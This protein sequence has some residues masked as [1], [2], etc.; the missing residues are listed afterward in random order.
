MDNLYINN[1]GY[2]KVGDT[3]ICEPSLTALAEREQRKIDFIVCFDKGHD[4]LFYGHP[5]INP[6]HQTI[7]DKPFD[8]EC[9]VSDAFHEAH[10]KAIPFG[11][12]MF[13]QF[14]LNHVGKRVHYK[15]YEMDKF[16]KESLKDH[17]C[18]NQVV[19]V[20]NGYSCTGRDSTTGQPKPGARPNIQLP[21]HMWMEVLDAV[22]KD[23]KIFSISQDN[24]WDY[25][26]FDCAKIM[27]TTSF[28][29]ILK[30]LQAA[31]LIISVETG[32]LHMCS[33]VK[34]NVIF[35]NAATPSFFSTPNC[36]CKNVRG[37]YADEI[38]TSEVIKEM[39]MI[40]DKS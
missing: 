5:W 22:P 2:A 36:P 20:P 12:G 1:H 15:N 39:N 35:L 32:I 25:L 38:R 8:Y 29:E 9:L 30:I 14:G 4:E 21:H 18:Y 19:I 24:P 3:I 10:A 31:A 16:P 6:I 33:S 40:L 34:T 13:T 11:A 23:R 7:R 17:P 27:D 37:W 28:M 26:K